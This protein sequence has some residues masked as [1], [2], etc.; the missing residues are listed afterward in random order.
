M[1]KSE[2]NKENVDPTLS[3]MFADGS[4]GNDAANDADIDCSESVISAPT[5]SGNVHDLTSTKL[6]ELEHS[7]YAL[8]SSLIAQHM[9]I[10][11]LV[12]GTTYPQ[13]IKYRNAVITIKVDHTTRFDES[14]LAGAFD[15]SAMLLDD[16]NQFLTNDY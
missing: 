12:T 1:E 10:N 15:L 7:L 16:Y 6:S 3:E 11:I 9:L 14:E 5:T 8:K 4:I 2:A 13:R